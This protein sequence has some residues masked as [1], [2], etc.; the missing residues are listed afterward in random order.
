[1]KKK[2]E[3]KQLYTELI[4]NGHLNLHAL[5][6]KKDYNSLMRKFQRAHKDEEEP[7]DGEILELDE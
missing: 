6:D 3:C 7:I 5:M 4:T 1:L 2:E